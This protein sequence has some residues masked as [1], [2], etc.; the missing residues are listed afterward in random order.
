MAGFDRVCNAAWLIR[1]SMCNEGECDSSSKRNNTLYGLFENQTHV[2]D[3][4]RPVTANM[5]GSFGPSTLSDFLDVQGLS[6]G[7]AG[8]FAAARAEQPEKPIIASECC[9]CLTQRDENDAILGKKYSSFNADCLQAEV[10]LTDSLPYVAG[11]MVWTLGDYLGEPA[12]IYWPQ[13]SSSFGS[14]DLAGFAKAGAFWY[15]SWWLYSKQWAYNISSAS[16]PPLPAGDVVYI[17]ENDEAWAERPMGYTQFHVYSS[18]PSVEFFQNGVSMGEKNNSEWMGWLQWSV[19]NEH[20]YASN[21]TAVAKNGGGKVVATH[22]RI[23]SAGPA[24]I[25]LSLDAPSPSTATGNKVLLDGH[26]VAL[27]RAALV[28]SRGYPVLNNNS[29][30]ITFEVIAGPGR[31]LGV[32]NGDPFCHQ[33][34]QVSWRTTYN[35]LVRAI[36]KV[37]V[38]A[39]SPAATR[40][41]MREIDVD[42]GRSTVH[43]DDPQA[44]PRT[45]AA[46]SVRASASK[47]QFLIPVPFL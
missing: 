36:I 44:P 17:V 1:Y 42:S 39:A 41:A 30:N 7:S 47:P 21:L 27:V 23:K 24:A 15:Q 29:I 8:E 22:T 20:K 16:R 14:F 32:G 34:H 6:H 12:H 46:I 35:G 11:S 19:N 13:V 25:K 40:L 9:S 18:A 37:T 10:G 5:F 33:P 26:D 31:V 2:L 45:L 43:V 3:P 38:D 28:D 4:Y